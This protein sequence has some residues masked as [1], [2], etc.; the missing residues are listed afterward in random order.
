MK[1]DGVFITIGWDETFNDELNNMWFKYI[2]DD[3]RAKNFEEWRTVRSSKINSARNCGLKWFKKGINVPLQFSSLK[4]SSMV[5]GYL[6]GR[7]AAQ[8]I[9]LKNQLD[10]SMSMGITLNTKEEIKLII[11][12]YEK[13]S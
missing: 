3:I 10:W 13:R 4:E 2:P 1:D 11:E 9:I 8:S 6:F 12:N 7:D 5:M